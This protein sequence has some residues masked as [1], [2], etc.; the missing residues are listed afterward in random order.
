M[1]SSP[2]PRTSIRVSP[3]TQVKCLGAYGGHLDELAL[4]ELDPV[5]LV[6]DPG[7]AHAVVVVTVKRQPV[8]SYVSC[9]QE[10]LRWLVLSCE[11]YTRASVAPGNL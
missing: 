4:D 3:L 8:T 7:L 9:P 10:H 11:K 1:A 2:T 5:V 6:Q